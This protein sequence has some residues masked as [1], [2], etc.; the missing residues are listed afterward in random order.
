M[1]QVHD[2][3]YNQGSQKAWGNVGA[4]EW[5]EDGILWAYGQNG[6]SDLCKTF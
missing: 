4:H 2:K 5:T 1:D 3:S 6:E